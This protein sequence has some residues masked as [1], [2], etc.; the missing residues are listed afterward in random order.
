MSI[1]GNLF[2]NRQDYKLP[3]PG[4]ISEVVAAAQKEDNIP[5]FQVGTTEDGRVTLRI[6]QYG[7]WVTMSDAGVEQLIAMLTAAKGRYGEDAA[8]DE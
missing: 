6:G 8:E 4:G 2:G 7:P 1:F 3:E 5:I